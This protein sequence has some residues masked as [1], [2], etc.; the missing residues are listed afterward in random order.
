[1]YGKTL[2]P[3][4]TLCLTSLTAFSGQAGAP[5]SSAEI[6][7]RIYRNAS[8]FQAQFPGTFI[9]R[10]RTVREIDP[11]DGAVQ[12]TFV[13][14]QEVSDRLGRR[15]EIKILSCEVNGKS[16]EPSDCKRKEGDR[17]PPYRIFGP[18]GRS[19]YRYELLAE[20]ASAKP[21]T[22]RLKV[23]P[24]ERTSRHF[25]G[26]LDFDASTLRLLAS[27]GTVADY[28]LGLKS[29]ELELLF[30]DLDGHPVPAHSRMDMTLYLP[31]VLNVRVLSEAKAY[32]QR[33][34]T[35]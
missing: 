5:A 24:R 11:D 27:R 33:F 6:I 25:E 14:E 29:L 12:K 2:V 13:S 31:L 18:E 4:L 10:T 3:A 15:P 23:I 17:K 1:M 32:D 9:R 8:D 28:P 26:I 22:Y 20:E 21:P 34:L 16:T 35:E 19:H 30:D 7:D